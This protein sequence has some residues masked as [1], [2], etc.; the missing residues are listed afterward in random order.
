MIKDYLKGKNVCIVGPA[1][2]INNT[3]KGDYIDSFDV[4][5]RINYAKVDNPSDTGTKTNVIYYDGSYHNHENLNLEYLVCSYPWTE[6]FYNE[7]CLPNVLKYSQ[8]FNHYIIDKDVYQNLKTNL[9]KDNK[10]R[11]NTGTIAIVDLLNSELNTLYITG[12]DFYRTSYLKSHPDY[13][14]TNLNDL[15][16]IF[17]QGDNGDVH[18]A[19]KQFNFFKNNIIQDNRIILDDFLKKITKQ[20]DINVRH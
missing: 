16:N 6:W 20:G 13:G 8:I 15:K 11:P 17:A 4:V 19:D 12:I 5:V 7:R 14:S 10:V 1:E 3:N 18:D 9:D 2:S